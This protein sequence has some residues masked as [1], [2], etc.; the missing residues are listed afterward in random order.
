MADPSSEYRVIGNFLESLKIDKFLKSLEDQGIKVTNKEGMIA[1]V[2]D[3]VSR[4]ITLQE[5]EQTLKDQGYD[6]RKTNTALEDKLESR[7]VSKKVEALE[8][9]IK[10][11]EELKIEL[12]RYVN[13]LKDLDNHVPIYKS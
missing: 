4:G 1:W 8:T 7:A 6:F 12:N 10:T 3:K 11:E 9:K 5:I 2:K 13:Y